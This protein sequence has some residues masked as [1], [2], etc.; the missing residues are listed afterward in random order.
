MVSSG[1]K[2]CVQKEV[3]ARCFGLW[4]KVCHCT[5][6]MSIYS[7]YSAVYMV[8]QK[9]QDLT[10]NNILRPHLS[11]LEL[12]FVNKQSLRAVTGTVCIHACIIL[13]LN[14]ANNTHL[15][16]LSDGV[17]SNVSSLICMCL[18]PS[19]LSRLLNEENKSSFIYRHMRQIGID[20]AQLVIMLRL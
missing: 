1:L 4:L 9:I 12:G 3:F 14:F 19:C 18:P 17:S 11:A 20:S 6:P 7:F 5:T 10:L 16:D 13:S 8:T 2:Q 15:A